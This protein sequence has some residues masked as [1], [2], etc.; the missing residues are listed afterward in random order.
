MG[1]SSFSDVKHGPDNIRNMEGQL[2][3]D[4]VE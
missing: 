2:S 1:K 4:Q 3:G